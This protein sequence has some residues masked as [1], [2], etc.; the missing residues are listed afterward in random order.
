MMNTIVVNV[1]TEQLQVIKKIYL[2]ILFYVPF[3]PK[4]KHSNVKYRI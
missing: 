1:P 4:N 2:L 3:S